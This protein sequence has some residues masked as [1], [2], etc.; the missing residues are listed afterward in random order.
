MQVKISKT[1][2]KEIKKEIASDPRFK[3]YY[4]DFCKIDRNYY[5]FYVD[6][7]LEKHITDYN[8]SDNTF[9]TFIIEY[10]A[11]FYANNL[12]ITT[13]DLLKIFHQSDKTYSGFINCFKDFIE[14]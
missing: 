6:Y 12:Y 9:N 10:P 3:N 2:L 8:A 11:D 4:I 14:V 5:G 1:L 13:Q 7:N